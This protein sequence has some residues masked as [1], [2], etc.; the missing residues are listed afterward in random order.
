MN[1]FL[2]RVLGASVLLSVLNINYL[3]LSLA[4]IVAIV[5]NRYFE[6][7]LNTLETQKKEIQDLAKELKSTI[8]ALETEQSVLKI[9]LQNLI[10]PGKRL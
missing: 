4:C 9:K 6:T 1:E 8:R 5:V 10:N 7:K 2:I 3:S